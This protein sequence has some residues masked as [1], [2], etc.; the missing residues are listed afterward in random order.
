MG[1]TVASLYDINV[2]ILIVENCKAS[3][4]YK[5]IF[6]IFYFDEFSLLVQMK[7]RSV[8]WMLFASCGRTKMSM[9]LCSS[10]PSVTT[11]ALKSSPAASLR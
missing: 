11:S 3:L 5:V 1:G 7:K 2:D 8:H 9:F 6:T 4:E 10:I